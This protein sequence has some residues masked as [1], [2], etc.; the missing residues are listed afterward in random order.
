MPDTTGNKPPKKYLEALYFDLPDGHDP[1][2]AASKPPLQLTYSF[3]PVAIANF[4]L[5]Y[6][7]WSAFSE[8]QKQAVRAVL[9]EYATFL[10][11]SFV[12]V[13]TGGDIDLY[14]GRTNIDSAG[15]GGIR[16]SSGSGGFDLD[17]YAIFD[18][19]QSLMDAYGRY[20]I[21]HEVGHA[22]T[23]KHPGGSNHGP[24]L[25]GRLDNNKYSVMSYTPNPDGG[26]LASHLMLYDIAALQARFGANLHY[27][28]G[29]DVYTRPGRPAAGD[30]G[31]RGNR[32]HRWQRPTHWR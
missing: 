10:N 8:S 28:T 9:A 7:G 24:F 26:G 3:E 12:E 15:F 11:V 20:V 17:G 27:R 16:W 13:T 6:S 22:M 18:S 31:R 5:G 32:H 30:L 29:N 1:L 19:G 2:H 25:P 14:L 23:L 4:D 21:L